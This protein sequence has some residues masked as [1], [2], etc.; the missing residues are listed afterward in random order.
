MKKIAPWVSLVALAVASQSHAAKHA[1]DADMYSGLKLRNL[2]PALTS[3]RISDFAVNPNKPS[4]YYVAVASGGVWK[5]QNAGT[6]WTPIFD[7]QNSFSIGD[8]T[9]DP[10]DS[11]VVWVGTGENNS[12]RSVGYGDGV[13][14]SL[15]GGKSWQHMGLKNSEHIAKILIDPRDS[16]KV[17]VASQGP[18]WSKGGDRGLF[19]TKDGGKTWKNVL[20]IDE[21]TG[22]TDLLMDPN[23]PN[24]MYA[25]SYQRRRHVWTLI[26]GGP[27]S[28][29]YKSVDGGDTWNK[30]SAGLP[31]GE[32][33]RIGLALAPSNPDTVYAVIEGQKGKGGFYRSTNAGQSW[34]KQGSY[35]TGSPQYYQEIEV[36]P[37]NPDRI[38]AMD[39]YMM[40]SED[41]GK[42]FKQL[43]EKDKHVDNHAIWINPAD[44]EHLRVGCDGG[45][46]ESW[47]RGQNWEFKPN[48]PVT[49]FYRV[50]VDNDYPFYSVYGGTQ[51]NFSL[52]VKSQTPY[53]HG[54][55]S[56]E[57]HITQLGDGFKTVI[58]PKDPNI[59]YSQAQY[60]W[61]SRIDKR[62]GEN[63]SIKPVSE[64]P[65]RTL[66]FN[67]NSPLLISPHDS[68][69]LYYAAER[70][71]RSDDKGNSWKE[72]SQDLSR[73][74]DRNTL[75]VM[76]K[77][78]S[79]DAVAKNAS[80]SLFGSVVS[81]T[82]SPLTQGVLYAGSDDGLMH[83]T[84]N[85]G[86]NW[87]Q[88]KVPR[89]VPDMT[90]VSDLKA[91]LHDEETVYAAFDNHKRGDFKP[92]LFVSN[93]YGRSWTDIS[94]N[95]PDRGTVHSLIQDHIDPNLLFVGTE[96]G[97]YFSQNAGKHWVQLKGNFPTVAVRDLDIQRREN[98]LAIATF[99]RGFYILDDYSP[100]RTK[101]K[102][103]KERSLSL[104]DVADALQ[105]NYYNSMGYSG[106]GFQGASFYT[107]D[108]P[109]YGASFTYYLD[110]GLTSLKAK[111][112]QA[113]KEKQK[114]G[115]EIA[116]PSWEALERE[117]KE[118]APQI[119]LTVRN[120]KGQTIRR[121]SGPTSAG[122]HRVAW[123]LKFAGLDVE[124]AEGSG[125]NV[126]PG[127]YSVSVSKLHNGEE[128]SLA[129]PRFFNVKRWDNSTLPSKATAEDLAFE[130]KAGRLYAAVTGA[131]EA[132][133]KMEAQV[134]S[135]EK[136]V[137]LAPQL[138]TSLLVKL[139]ALRETLH[140]VR[141]DLYGNKTISSRNE[142]APESITSFIS[143]VVGGRGTTTS[144][145]TQ[146]QK[147]M[148]EYAHSGYKRVVEQLQQ[149]DREL[150]GIETL[151]NERQVPYTPGRLLNWEI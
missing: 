104:F 139:A 61:L 58:D 42:T 45:V 3:G 148:Y 132:L 53:E 121:L 120:D 87:K 65:S 6:T 2:G 12:Q 116:Y 113:E 67:W 71:L 86:E 19:K 48:L 77:V 103:L 110:K 102:S 23:N 124:D 30:V 81:L 129:E 38:Y 57:W 108:N 52:G 144:E 29:I 37:R 135:I 137:Q 133:K 49:Q 43:G 25:A 138:E 82:E 64:D 70:V 98:D 109:E 91:S 141:T 5:T 88:L 34:H 63:I 28:A 106:K 18:L 84:K 147:T 105:Y 117:D 92:Y 69:R 123:D 97:L 85:G 112:Q 126:L 74:M 9:L 4:E 27:G 131:G 72:I 10:N 32:L 94:S 143:R 145:V 31:G 11:N 78:W 47:D 115:D 122:F 26:N 80:T 100:L 89:Q 111:R 46:Y 76:D 101:A 56:G 20:E 62:S 107:A 54:I 95:L 66:R 136:A 114:E 149:V 79:V 59:L 14:K 24:V 55:D 90:Y 150:G 130:Q 16:N 44:T 140:Q 13:Y 96:F 1:G 33:G 83:V 128:T 118:L 17:F 93:N 39:T 40:V 50:A 36:D 21:H 22:V 60:G 151:L 146:T 75:K 73:N 7:G 125:P 51:D 127:K 35:V 119:W 8:V 15:D 99:G 68:N 134:K 41:A 142:S